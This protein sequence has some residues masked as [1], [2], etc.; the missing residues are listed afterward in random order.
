MSV[1][2]LGKIKDI[3]VNIENGPVSCKE[4]EVDTVRLTLSPSNVS[5]MSDFSL[6]SHLY[7]CFLCKLNLTVVSIGP[8]VKFQRKKGDISMVSP[9]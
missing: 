9:H 2:E 5:T 1:F 3:S 7:K 8:S 4:M 6:D